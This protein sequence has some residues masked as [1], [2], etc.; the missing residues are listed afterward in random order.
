VN[1]GELVVREATL[2]LAEP[3]LELF[4]RADCPCHCQYYGFIGE[5][6]D[7]QNRCANDRQANRDGLVA[8]L[9]AGR[10]RAWVALDGER[11]VGWLRVAPVTELQKTYSGRLYRG[12][13]CFDGDRS[14]VLSVA[15]FLVDPAVRRRGV[16]SRL[17]DEAIAWARQSG[18]RSL[19]ALPRG[20]S[21]VSD[22]EQWTG[23]LMLY[24]CAG[25]SVIRDFQ[26]YPVLR[27]DLAPT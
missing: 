15:C 24:E 25:F 20:A 12:L 13:P 18:A 1:E 14:R 16:A 11:A 26:P 5:H 22:E 27:L 17:L 8:D 7:W 23:P 19:E 4:A 6:R 2:E 10:L 21:D 9:A 3:A